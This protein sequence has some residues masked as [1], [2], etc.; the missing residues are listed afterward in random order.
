MKPS[1][2]KPQTGAE[3]ILQNAISE[4]VANIRIDRVFHFLK[5]LYVPAIHHR[6]W[7]LL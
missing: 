2:I 5:E 7:L 4:W 3:K 1:P 6:I